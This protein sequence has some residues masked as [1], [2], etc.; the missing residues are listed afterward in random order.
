[1]ECRFR[2]RALSQLQHELPTP[3]WED[4]S[5]F[6]SWLLT[7]SLSG[8]VYAV[9]PHSVLV[10]ARLVP[11]CWMDTGV[12]NNSGLCGDIS[13]NS[14]SSWLNSSS[15][16]SSCKRRATQINAI[17]SET[18]MFILEKSPWNMTF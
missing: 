11:R 3:P 14:T 10:I 7:E 5:F 16:P 13:L 17:F 6:S 9:K 8:C 2:S 15:V 4:T 12:L 1:M 18:E